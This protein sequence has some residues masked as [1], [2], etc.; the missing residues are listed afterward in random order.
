MGTE[1]RGYLQGFYSALKGVLYIANTEGVTIHELVDAINET[2]S[3]M[4]ADGEL[5][6]IDTR[7]DELIG[8]AEEAERQGKVEEF[9]DL[10]DE[11][12]G[13]REDK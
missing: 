12:Y 10:L 9:F 1:E 5:V 13:K 11:A 6:G 2:L 7:V 4:E 8:L 3:D